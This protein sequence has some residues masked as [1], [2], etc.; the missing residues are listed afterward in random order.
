MENLNENITNELEETVAAA[1][2]EV[3]VKG[4]MKPVF[5]VAIGVGISAVVG[6]AA[7][8]FVL[9]PM[10]AKRKA[11]AAAKDDDNGEVTVEVEV[12]TDKKTA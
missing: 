9:K 4:G 1:A 10:I 7:Y 8:R 11:S 3:I 5:K 2:E 12:E 6:Y